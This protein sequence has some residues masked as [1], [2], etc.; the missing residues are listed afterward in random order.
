LL[1]QIAIDIT[2]AIT[3]VMYELLIYDDM[4]NIVCGA[5]AT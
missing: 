5:G 1:V 4:H 2:I 3:S